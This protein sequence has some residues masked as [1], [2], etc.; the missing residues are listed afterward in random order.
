MGRHMGKHCGRILE[1]LAA[2]VD[3]L[4][5]PEEQAEIEQHLGRCPPCRTCASEEDTARI[6]LKACAPRLRSA[7]VSP[8]LRSRCEASL[9]KRKR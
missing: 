6:V 2:F 4:L 5:S 7:A 3:H 1:R 8:E 9:R